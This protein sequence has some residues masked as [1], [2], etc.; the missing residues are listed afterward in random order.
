MVD[1][2]GNE[3]EMVFPADPGQ[4]SGRDYNLGF[5]NSKGQNNAIRG[6]SDRSR[7]IIKEIINVYPDTL[8]WIHD[9]TYANNEYMTNMY[10]LAQSKCPL[11]KHLLLPIGILFY[12]NQTL[13]KSYVMLY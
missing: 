11:S 8:C 10:F 4:V 12:F 3:S 7:F 5:R 2:Q 1:A 9:F 13:F 6:H